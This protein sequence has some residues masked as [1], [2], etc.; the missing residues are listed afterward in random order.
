MC[1]IAGYFGNDMSD[2]N[3]NVIRD[4][5]DIL[6]SG[7]PDFQQVQTFEPNIIFGH[8]RLSILDL[9]SAANQPFVWDKYT[10]CFNGE[11]YNFREIK[12][13]LIQLGYTF[14]TTSDTE[15]VI[16]S[17][18]AWGL[19]SISRF[20][21]MFAF[22]IWDSVEE[23]FYLVRDRLGVKPLYYIKCKNGLYFFSE[24]K[25]LS[26]IPGLKTTINKKAI[27]GFLKRGYINGQECVYNEVEKVQQG[28]IL[29]FDTK[30]NI[31]P[32]C[33]WNVNNFENEKFQGDYLKGKYAVKDALIQSINYR[34]ISDVPV[35][36]FLSGGI[37]SSLV[38]SIASRELGVKLQTFT[39]SFENKAFN[40]AH[41][42]RLIA[43]EMGTQ[44]HEFLCSN[45][46]LF[47]LVDELA[48]V[49]D[50]PFGDASALPTLFLCKKTK[51]HVKVALGGDGGDEV[52]GG[53]V[54][55][56]F[57]SRFKKNKSFYRSFV[58]LMKLIGNDNAIGISKLMLEKNYKNVETK[59]RKFLYAANSNDWLEFF[60]KSG[61]YISDELLN[62][63]LSSE[64]I[65]SIFPNKNFPDQNGVF[66]SSLG[67]LDI[68]SYLESDLLT[69]VDRAS[70]RFGLEAREPLLDHNLVQLGLS[71]PDE[72]KIKRSAT[73]FI[74]RDILSD[75]LPDTITTA[76]KAGF[77]VPVD[78][79][80]RNEL[81][82][83]CID[84]VNDKD[85]HFKFS[86]NEKVLK[87]IIFNF[88]EG[89]ASTEGLF[90][91]NLLMLYKWNKKWQ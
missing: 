35:G 14:Q 88:F 27:H 6:K 41:L 67:I 42:A 38:T 62:Q 69:K 63:L 79:W 37:D 46:I 2:Q 34:L 56:L 61:S 91:W 59:I 8:A 33:Y 5:I 3:V 36:V 90:I 31:N 44:H 29:V 80:L 76:S 39:V 81:K 21:G 75:Y 74:L 25:A 13:V 17:F 83:Q 1:R 20:T 71:L 55:Y 60:E 58:Y 52:F 43:K 15:V 47:E 18:D 4:M 9:S 84:M 86:L 11:I 28:H 7:G 53:Y 78:N 73:K 51:E 77:S 85:F 66:L 54:K 49:F 16:K 23:K 89:R 65:Q 68:K 40:E 72:W 87:K 57:T 30:H 48:F 45:N 64:S 26:K 32:F 19:D 12:H 70:M 22:A 82:L 24:L 50:E 10:I